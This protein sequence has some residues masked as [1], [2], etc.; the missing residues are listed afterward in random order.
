MSVSIKKGIMKVEGNKGPRGV[1][2]AALRHRNKV[3][4]LESESEEARIGEVSGVGLDWILCVDL[5]FCPDAVREEGP[6]IRLVSDKVSNLLPLLLRLGELKESKLLLLFPLKA[7]GERRLLFWDGQ[8]FLQKL[9]S[10]V[11]VSLV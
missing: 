5:V 2:S 9:H 10:L 6:G 4:F 11:V 3:M 1:H 7:E 8:F